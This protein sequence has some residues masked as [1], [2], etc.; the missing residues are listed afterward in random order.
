MLKPKL[1]GV[2]CAVVQYNAWQVRATFCNETLHVTFP[3][4]N[5]NLSPFPR[6]ACAESAV[7]LVTQDTPE[8]VAARALVV[9]TVGFSAPLDIPG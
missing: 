8:T 4:A 1:V 3:V 2:P 6:F 5:V 7:S 9:G